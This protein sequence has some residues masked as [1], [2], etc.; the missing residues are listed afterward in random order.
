MK[1]T[2]P[3][4]FAAMILLSLFPI[5]VGLEQ[6]IPNAGAFL[7]IIA[8]APTTPTGTPTATATT[9]PVATITPTGTLFVPSATP[10]STA[11]SDFT[12]TPT[13]IR[14]DVDIY[15]CSDFDTQSEA[16]AVFDYCVSQNAGDIHGLDSNNDGEACEPLPR[17][18]INQ[19]RVAR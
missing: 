5:V 4:G 11:T 1:R 17:L 2:L 6:T 8:V 16:Q 18:G 7:P 12:P 14:C 10:T 19:Q 9:A 13:G 3:L 15:N